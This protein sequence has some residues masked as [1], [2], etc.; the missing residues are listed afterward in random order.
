MWFR[1]LSVVWVLSWPLAAYFGWR[2]WCYHRAGVVMGWCRREIGLGWY[3]GPANQAFREL[4]DS[5][6]PSDISPLVRFY[7]AHPDYIPEACAPPELTSEE[8]PASQRIWRR[9]RDAETRREP[10]DL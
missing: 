5:P 1:I 4:I 2:A 7:N 6:H 8:T 10:G 9:Y 3:D